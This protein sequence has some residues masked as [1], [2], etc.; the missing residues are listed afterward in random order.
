[1]TK[2]E[3][4]NNRRNFFKL[5]TAGG[6]GAA[7]TPLIAAAPAL[8]QEEKKKPATPKTN[9]DEALKIPRTKDSLPGKYPGK[10]VKVD[11]PECVAENVINEDI[12]YKMLEASMLELTGEK[13]LKKAW[14]QFVSPGEVIGL[15]VNPVAGKQLST[16]HE[17]V[18]SIIKQLEL[19]GVPKEHIVIWDRREMQLHEVGFTQENYPGIK[20]RGTEQ[21]DA[22]GGFYDKDGVLYGEK[23]IDKEWYYWADVEGEYD[24]Y[25]IPYMVNGGKYSYFSKICTQEVDKIINVPILKNAGNTVTLCLKNLAYGSISNTGRLHKP[26]WSETCAQ[27][28]AFPPIRDKVVLNIVDGIKGCYN[29][30]PS[31]VPQFFCNYKTI[32]VGSDPVAVDR[33]A[34]DLVVKKRIEE[35]KQKEDTPRY[36][37]FMLLAEEYKLGIADREKIELKTIQL[38]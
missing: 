18:R 20:I 38:A 1:M 33:T 14:L 25:T 5:I 8:A 4:P 22:E 11:H 23:M 17:V 24:N 15:K 7:V 28:C 30:G 34:H 12:A 29:G 13:E 10:V 21:Q 32:M 36:N 35:G 37:T 2:K 26:L 16:S 27:V 31:A 9:I 3:R 6:I 19:A